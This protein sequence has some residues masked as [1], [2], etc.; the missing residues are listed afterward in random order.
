MYQFSSDTGITLLP[1]E[2]GFLAAHRDHL[3]E[4]AWHGYTTYGRGC[5]VIAA[6][7]QQDYSVSYLRPFEL[8]PYLDDQTL[9][10]MSCSIEGYDPLRDVL[11][12]VV[13][14]ADKVQIYCWHL[15]QERVPTLWHHLKTA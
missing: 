14:P 5:I 7:G 3:V 1:G 10:T 9:H 6:C 12:L 8:I 2:A 4:M 13:H 15:Q 11:C